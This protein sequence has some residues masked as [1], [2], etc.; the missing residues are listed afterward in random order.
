MA[1]SQSGELELESTDD[2]PEEQPGGGDGGDE[3]HRSEPSPTDEPPS[4]ARV[5]GTGLV[6]QGAGHEDAVHAAWEAAAWEDD[7]AHR[8]FIAL[9]SSL[10]RLD[11]AGKLYRQ[12]K[13]SDPAR[14]EVAEQRIEKLIA[15]AMSTME[16]T[17]EVPEAEKLKKPVVILGY[18]I[19][20]GLI[21]FG[22]WVFVFR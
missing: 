4:P 6:S 10:G 13:E 5:G 19:A 21:G 14:A 7:E 18:L 8:K 12:I 16:F 9:C 15:Q 20:L 11:L 22:I 1:D 3:N 17:R 2:P